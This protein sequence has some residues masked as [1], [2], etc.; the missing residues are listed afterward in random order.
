MKEVQGSKQDWRRYN[1]NSWASQ[2]LP[3]ILDEEEAEDIVL[4]REKT[5]DSDKDRELFQMSQEMVL[6]KPEKELKRN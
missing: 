1:C 4:S 2:P 6:K 5:N 3:P